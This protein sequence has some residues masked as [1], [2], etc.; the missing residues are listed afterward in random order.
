MR[1]LPPPGGCGPGWVMN[2]MRINH[3]GKGGTVPTA[4]PVAQELRRTRRKHLAQDFLQDAYLREI[5]QCI[6]D[7]SRYF[8]EFGFN[9]VGYE[10]VGS[11]PNTHALHVSGWRGLLLDGGHENASINLQRALLYQSNIASVFA[12]H[13]VPRELDYLSVDMDSHDLFVLRAILRSGH[14]PRL[15]TTEFNPNYWGRPLAFSQLDPT[16]ETGELPAGYQWSSMTDSC[17]WGASAWAFHTLLAQEYS[18]RLVALSIGHGTDMFFVRADQLA[19]GVAVP[20][21][22]DLF[23]HAGI[24]SSRVERI[25]DDPLQLR[26]LPGSAGRHYLWHGIATPEQVS[27]IV[28][29]ATYARTGNVKRSLERARVLLRRNMS[30]SK[31]FWAH[32]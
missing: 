8:V 22:S 18:Y 16:L 19:A 32:A 20:T 27:S 11:G 13:A 3:N 15:I 1:D 23:L 2:L 30:D 25:C 6:G 4:P 9:E 7:G 17:A 5:L 26:R 21:F 29:Y 10:G 14:R 28:D 12:K 31:C 24:H